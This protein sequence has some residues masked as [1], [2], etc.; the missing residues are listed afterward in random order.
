M[1]HK[2]DFTLKGYDGSGE[3]VQLVKFLLYRQ[4]DLTSDPRIQVK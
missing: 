2:Q 3:M 4:E 1:N